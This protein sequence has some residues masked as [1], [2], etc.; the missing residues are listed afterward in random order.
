FSG[1]HGKPEGAFVAA[2]KMMEDMAPAVLWFD[3]IEMGIT[4]TESGGD[5]GRIFA[6]FL[7]GMQEKARGLFVA[8]TANRIDLLPAEMIRKGRFD[9]VFFVDLPTDEE[10]VE[11]FKIH[12]EQRG[13]AAG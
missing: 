11:I 4:S 13:V 5:E 9:E 7:T 3:E 1:R 8:A 12:L 2:C 6:F 10:R